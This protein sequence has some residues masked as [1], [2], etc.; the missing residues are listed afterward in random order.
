MFKLQVGEWEEVVF[1]DRL[2]PGAVPVQPAQSDPS[3]P[4]PQGLV[5]AGGPVAEKIDELVMWKIRQIVRAESASFIVPF[6]LLGSGTEFCSQKIPRNRLGA[7][8]VIPRK[9]VLIPSSAEEPI[10]KL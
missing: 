1:I 5:L 3:L 6:Y 4:H 10:P 7:V 2:K 9:K 8:S